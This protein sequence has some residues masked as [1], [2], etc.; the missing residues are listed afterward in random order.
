MMSWGTVNGSVVDSIDDVV[1]VLSV[2]SAADRLSCAEDLLHDSAELPGHGPGPHDS[3]SSDDII[4]G[5]VA[6]MLDVLDLLS[7]PW[8]FLQGLDNEGSSAGYHRTLGL[9]VLDAELHGHLQALPFLSGL[10]D[11]VTNLLGR[12]TKG[13]DLGGKG[14]S[15]SHFTSN[16]PE[17][18]E[19]NGCRIKFG[20]HI[21]S[22]SGWWMRSTNKPLPRRCSLL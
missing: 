13:T 15:G 6:A 9:P 16:G 10:G 5:D 1:G 14:R 18:D 20:S 21:S 17:V 22:S 2:N 19:R 3:C 7:V 11:V 12:Q 4:H 8:G